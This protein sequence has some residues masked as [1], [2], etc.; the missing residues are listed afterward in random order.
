MFSWRFVEILRPL[1]P[2]IPPLPD[3][4]AYRR[5]CGV[6][7]I[8]LAE[9]LIDCEIC[10]EFK[11]LCICALCM[12]LHAYALYVCVHIYVSSIYTAAGEC[13]FIHI[14]AMFLVRV[15]ILWALWFSH[16]KS[17]MLVP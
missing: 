15:C 7:K 1:F 13:I 9:G 17:L 4:K 11:F 12:C 5:L 14:W 3:F 6:K 2:C 16:V 10:T 8:F